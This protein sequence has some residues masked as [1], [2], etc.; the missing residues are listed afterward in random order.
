M[1]S[2]FYLCLIILLSNVAF[3]DFRCRGKGSY[4]GTKS[5]ANECSGWDDDRT[6]YLSIGEGACIL[7]PGTNKIDVLE[8]STCG[9]RGQN[10]DCKKS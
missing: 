5:I 9:S 6:E 7:K 1:I 4:S 2:R 10:C 8:L 3:A